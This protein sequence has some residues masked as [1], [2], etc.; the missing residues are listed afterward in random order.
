MSRRKPTVE[1]VIIERVAAGGKCLARVDQQ[2]I[3]VENVVPGD[4]VDVRL[5]RRKKRYAEAVPL[6]LREPSPLRQP[7]FCEHFG[8]CGGCKWQ[9]LP[10]ETQLEFK[11]QQ[12]QD[13]LERI[14]HLE[15][16]ALRPI[17]PSPATR[18]Y[19]NKLEFTFT[20]ERWLTTEEIGSDADLDRRA[21][22]FHVPKRY[23][24]ILDIEHCYLQPDPSNAVR[25]AVRD[26]AKAHG[27]PFFNLVRQEGF[28]RNL[29]VRTTTTGEVMVI[30][31]LFYDDPPARAGLLDFLAESFPDLTSL[32]WVINGKGN[33]TFHDLEVHLHSGRDHLIE[34]M[35]ELRFRIGPKSFFQTNATQALTLY[36]VARDLAGLTGRERVWDLYTGTGTIACFVA[37]AAAHVVG[38][39]A[40]EGAVADARRNAAA[41][42][43][44]NAHFLAGD[45]RRLLTDE[46]LREHGR[47][48]V[49]ITDP[50]RAGMHPDVVEVLLRAAPARIVYVSC[51]PATQARDLAALAAAYD[52]AVV[53]PVDMFPHTYH[54][55]NV[56]LLTRKV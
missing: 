19:R 39:E 28:L 35:E 32:M 3:F 18:Y 41:N 9:N 36:R 2:V 14:G 30:L 43:I 27:L 56:V 25:L 48:D 13:Q 23:D 31:Q 34:Q 16:P 10:Y 12:V 17:L 4:V 55:E 21:L 40:V 20:D 53:Q 29:I 33:E 50:P 45:T 54:V 44:E 22:G 47:P 52:V 46:F 8:T 38:I 26:Y 24:R 6:R 37:G 15:L 11:Q 1:G 49:V 42:G 7:A 5:M 51:N